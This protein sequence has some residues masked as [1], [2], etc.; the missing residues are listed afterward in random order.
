MEV[1][2]T[3]SSQ[4]PLTEAQYRE[5]YARP[6]VT[7]AIEAASTANRQILEGLRSMDQAVVKILK[8]LEQL[9]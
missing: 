2:D 8:E 9:Q 6:L 4:L 5:L 1:P 7:G 3:N